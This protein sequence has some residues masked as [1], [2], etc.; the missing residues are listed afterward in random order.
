MK[1]ISD[2]DTTIIRSNVITNS[3]LTPDGKVVNGIWFDNANRRIMVSRNLDSNYPTWNQILTICDIPKLENTIFNYNFNYNYLYRYINDYGYAYPYTY[4]YG[5][6]HYFK[7][8]VHV[9]VFIENEYEY[10]YEYP[11]SYDYPYSYEYSYSYGYPYSY[12]YNYIHNYNYNYGCEDQY[13]C[14]GC[15]YSYGYEYPYGYSYPYSYGYPYS[16]CY[17]YPY[18]YTYSYDY[19]YGYDYEYPYSYPYEYPYGY[20]YGYPY[21]YD[22]EYKYEYSYE[23]DYKY[24]YE[25]EYKYDYESY[26]ITEMETIPKYE[27]YA[28]L[29]YKFVKSTEFTEMGYKEI[30]TEYEIPASDFTPQ[31]VPYKDIVD[32]KPATLGVDK[33]VTVKITEIVPITEI[34]YLAK[35]TENKISEG[36]IIYSHLL[37]I[38]CNGTT[39]KFN[40]EG[41]WDNEGNTTEIQL[42]ESNYRLYAPSVNPQTVGLNEIVKK[43][44]L[45]VTY[46]NSEY[47]PVN[48][49][50]IPGRYTIS[51]SD[52]SDIMSL[53]SEGAEYNSKEYTFYT[54]LY[55]VTAKDTTE[56]HETQFRAFTAPKVV[57][58]DNNGSK[59]FM[60]NFSNDWNKINAFGF[61]H[62]YSGADAKTKATEFDDITT[63]VSLINIKGQISIDQFGPVCNG[64]KSTEILSFTEYKHITSESMKTAEEEWPLAIPV[65]VDVSADNIVIDDKSQIINIIESGKITINNYPVMTEINTA[66]TE[67]KYEQVNGPDGI[68]L[69]KINGTTE[70]IKSV[71]TEKWKHEIDDPV[72][73]P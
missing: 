10:E 9:P 41:D 45:T 29:L 11:Y 2:I 21:D 60:E 48:S 20:P 33:K 18:E 44:K 23:Y 63:N 61:N 1:F 19:L 26:V 38:P 43:I 59:S 64:L 37:N 13:G 4:G 31:T 65:S 22:Y 32:Y 57:K 30:D 56:I 47:D 68:Q 55:G 72:F 28:E 36:K 39:A 7:E 58:S 51:S 27:P 73:K 35:L 40:T 66:A 67:Y 15:S 71:K 54:M 69:Y 53:P 34:E 50:T 12:G 16:Y 42:T 52:L 3:P 46:I 5:Y 70:I 14:Y 25:Y 17:N 62:N 8:I 6:H 49:E 24:E